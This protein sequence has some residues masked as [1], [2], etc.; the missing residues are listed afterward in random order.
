VLEGVAVLL[1]VG[2]LTAF[3]GVAD[4]VGNLRAAGGEDSDFG[5]GGGFGVGVCAPRSTPR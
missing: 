1:G 5:L 3:D 2:D 4:G